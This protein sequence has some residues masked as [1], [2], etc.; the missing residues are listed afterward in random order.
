M[1]ATSHPRELAPTAKTP[2]QPAEPK[3]STRQLSNRRK[4]LAAMISI[5]VVG[6]LQ[7][8]DPALHAVAMPAAAKALGMDPG[9]ASF[10]KSLGTVVLAASLLG[11]GIIGDNKGRKRTL[12]AGVFL[13]TAASLITATAGTAWMFGIGRALTGVGTALS[14]SMCLAM[15]P[16]IYP[17]A[18]LPKAFGIFFGVGASVIVVMTSLS[19]TI[20]TVFGWRFNYVSAALIC[21]LAGLIAAA[22]LPETKAA[23]PRK[24]DLPGVLLAGFGLVALVYSIGRASGMGWGAPEVLVGLGLAAVL[25]AAFAMWELRAKDP[26]FPMHLFRIP[27]FSAACIAGVLFNWAD[28]SLLGQYPALAIPAGVAPGAVSVIVAVM[29]VGMIVGA[30]VAGIAQRRFAISNR[31]MFTSGLLLCAFG[32][33][34]QLFL[35]HPGNIL[36]PGVGL[37]IVG[38]AVMWM[39]NPQAAVILGS[40]PQD[41]LGAVG[42]VKPAVGQFGFGLGFAIAGPIAGIFMTGPVLDVQAYGQGLAFQ[43]GIFVIAAV[44]VCWLLRPRRS[45]TAVTESQS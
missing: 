20:Q 17:K 3:W 24:F 29:Y 32:L 38:F 15:I 23:R 18:E 8:G 35:D 33:A 2:E 1:V 5:A 7:G 30:A 28:A 16:A 9:L 27:A 43:A 37:F 40:A 36:L 21:L 39:Q 10:L 26:G 31:A 25:L 6:S 12:L 44:L 42:A 34:I 13:M 22:L 11:A 19:G 45:E 4:V 41:Q 14:F